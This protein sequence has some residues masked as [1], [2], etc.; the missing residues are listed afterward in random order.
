M[1]PKGTY[2]SSLLASGGRRFNFPNDSALGYFSVA[3]GPAR[4]AEGVV[5]V[6]QG[7][8]TRLEVS[9][10][11]GRRPELLQQ[12]RPDDITILSCRE[13][14][15]WNDKF[16]EGVTSHLKTVKVLE[17]TGCDL[18]NDCIVHLN[19]LKDLMA[20]SIGDTNITGTG[21]A[22]LHTLRQLQLL[23]AC[24][25]KDISAALQCLKGSTNLEYLN[26]E[27]C[28]TSDADIANI[29]TMSAL[30]FLGLNHNKISQESFKHLSLLKELNYLGLDDTQLG[31]DAIGIIHDFKKLKRLR[32]DTKYWSA[33]DIEKLKK[34]VPAGCTI[35]KKKTFPSARIYMTECW[36]LK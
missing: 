22:G 27:D 1:L 34:A 15:N 3:N 17:L 23:D 12:F 28:F 13:F 19:R 20:L 5:F 33:S 21:L 2:Y 11:L 6:P 26:V 4:L 24:Q 9:A 31:P 29:G 16:V 32:M 7:S 8:D 36:A 35:E 14:A 25:T 30:T 10:E 18:G